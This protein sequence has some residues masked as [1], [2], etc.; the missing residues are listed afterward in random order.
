MT[1]VKK[2][3]LVEMSNDRDSISNAN[4]LSPVPRIIRHKIIEGDGKSRLFYSLTRQNYVFIDRNGFLY[5]D[6]NVVGRQQREII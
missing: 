2:N 6:H 5:L 1:E 4:G 3:F